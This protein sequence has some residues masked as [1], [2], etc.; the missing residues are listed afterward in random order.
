MF[1]LGG[2]VRNRSYL[3]R[4]ETAA[5]Q[6]TRAMYDRGF[7]VT[8]GGEGT[9]S[10]KRVVVPTDARSEFLANR[11]LGDWAEKSLA[12]AIRQVFPSWGVAH[13]GQS[14]AMSAGD[15]G[16]RE[17]YLQQLEHVRTNGK[18]PDLLL[19]PELSI[20]N[21]VP[22][23]DISM[24]PLEQSDAFA[25]HAFASIEVRS[26]KVEALRYMEVRKQDRLDG[27]ST[28]ST[29]ETP[30]FTV[31]AED[32]VIVYRWI[33]KY[34]V[35]QS[36][37]QVFFDSV[38]G[39]NF[40]DIFEWIGRGKFKIDNPDKSQGKATIL[41]PI[42]EGTLLGRF[43]HTPHQTVQPKI[44][45]LGRHDTYIEPI[46]EPG[47]LSIDS[48]SLYSVLTGGQRDSDAQFNQFIN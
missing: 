27:R 8:F 9:P 2:T 19:F 41:I 18:R 40:V 3:A 6:V 33:E 13:Y 28:A 7:S 42:T 34:Q 15:P 12:Q 32:L 46:Y 36:Y 37:C 48:D 22:N 31:K 17:F 4:L 20:L 26:S 11:A 45:R 43:H 35:S 10:S 21:G 1:Y 16:F 39:M 47:N 30:S 24:L 44:S 5:E 29:R 25:Q 23:S 38:F 14:D